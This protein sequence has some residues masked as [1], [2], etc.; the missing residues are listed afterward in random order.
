MSTLPKRPTAATTGAMVSGEM[1]RRMLEIMSVYP[2]AILT[3]P[4]TYW[5]LEWYERSLRVVCACLQVGIGSN[6]KDGWKVGKGT[7]LNQWKSRAN[8]RLNPCI[9]STDKEASRMTWAVCTAFPPAAAHNARNQDGRSQNCQILL[10][11]KKKRQPK[12]R[13]IGNSVLCSIEFG[14]LSIGFLVFSCSSSS[15]EESRAFPSSGCLCFQLNWM[16]NRTHYNVGGSMN[17][18]SFLAMAKEQNSR[19]LFPAS[20][21]AVRWWGD[22]VIFFERSSDIHDTFSIGMRTQR[23]ICHKNNGSI[24]WTLPFNN[25]TYS[26]VYHQSIL[27]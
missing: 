15:E 17:I 23:A 6:L 12:P 3:R 4:A 14:L 11:A 20:V 7:A 2:M 10:H 19:I 13:N 27:Q 1:N 22:C 8:S 18:I 9:D 5:H 26:L 21:V 16:F 24:T 25:K